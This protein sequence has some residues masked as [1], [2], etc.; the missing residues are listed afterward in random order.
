MNERVSRLVNEGVG[1]SGWVNKG[2]NEWGSKYE[3]VNEL[4]RARLNE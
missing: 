3:G 2:V 4:V 1:V